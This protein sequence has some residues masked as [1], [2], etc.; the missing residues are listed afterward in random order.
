MCS[1]GDVKPLIAPPRRRAS[2]FIV[3]TANCVA[4]AASHASRCST[5]TSGPAA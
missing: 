5:Q 3:D 4:P 2:V 1:A